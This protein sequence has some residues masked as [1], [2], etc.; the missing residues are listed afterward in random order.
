M[1]IKQMFI[2]SWKNN[3]IVFPVFFGVLLLVNLFMAIIVAVLPEE[4]GVSGTNGSA[5]IVALVLGLI[6]FAYALRWGGANSVSRRSVYVGSLAFLASFAVVL[7]VLEAAMRLAFS[8]NPAFRQGEI[9]HFL[10][11]EWSAEKGFAFMALSHLI[12]SI[13][14]ALLLHMIGYFLGGAFY[15]LGRIGKV[16]LAAGT[17]VTLLVVLPIVTV[18][19]PEGVQAALMSFF[20]NL[21]RF[22]MQT[23]F[24]MALVFLVISVV[25][26]F[27]A[28]LLV[29]KAP[30]NP[31]PLG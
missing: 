27:F 24:H 11:A 8:W 3:W 17:P 29:R 19:L 7:S 5:F 1:K 23:P 9:F 28:W 13:A 2:W 14:M 4:G 22:L 12:W 26:A 25:F 15:R 16:L 21:F 6:N 31:A 18:I 20:G 30:V 10:F